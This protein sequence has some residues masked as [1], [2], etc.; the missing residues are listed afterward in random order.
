M[1][2][3]FDGHIRDTGES[4]AELVAKIEQEMEQMTQ[5]QLE[6]QVYQKIEYLVCPDCR[7]EIERFLNLSDEGTA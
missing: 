6:K 5:K 2:S 1:I 7:D 3:H 4:L